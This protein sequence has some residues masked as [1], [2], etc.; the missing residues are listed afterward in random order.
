MN[1]HLTPLN[2][3]LLPLLGIDTEGLEQDEIVQAIYDAGTLE[4]YRIRDAELYASARKSMDETA[5]VCESCRHDRPCEDD[6]CL[7]YGWLFDETVGA[8][9]GPAPQ[10]EREGDCFCDACGGFQKAG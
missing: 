5:F 4:G 6:S 10:A 7:G 2:S 1:N 8:V 9:F 3:A